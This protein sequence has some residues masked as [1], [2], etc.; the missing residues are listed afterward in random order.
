LGLH[1][2][3]RV[4]KKSAQVFAGLLLAALCGMAQSYTISAKPGAVNYIE[5]NA[6]L[7][8]SPLS[9]KDLKSTFLNTNDTLAT[10]LGKAEVLLTPG[11]FLRMDDNSQIRM[12]SASLTDTQVEV[13]RGEIMIEA[14]G[15]NKEN[16]IQILDHG[17][18]TSLGK[19]GLYRFT[20]DDPP[21]AAVLDGKAEVLFGDRKVSLKKGKEAI[22]SADRQAQSF[23][24][25]KDDELYAWSNVRSEYDA[26]ASYRVAR[27]ASSGNFGGWYGYGFM[28]CLVQGGY[29]TR[30]SV[31]MHGYLVPG[32]S[33][34]PSATDSIRR[35]WW[36]MHQ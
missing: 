6:F 19:N 1:M 18:V 12:V 2:M 4:G 34:A 21:R 35:V 3:T 14:T 13:V 16:S 25:K 27:S 22:L 7:N 9:D 29:T 23:D 8:G 15:L 24:T 32:P 36:A 20:A 11:V 26:A 17:S 5:G 10:D 30:L 33:T 28:E 31:R